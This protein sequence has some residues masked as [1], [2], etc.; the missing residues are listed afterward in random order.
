MTYFW[1]G[2]CRSSCSCTTIQLFPRTKG[3]DWRTVDRA[4]A[5]HTSELRWSRVW[6]SMSLNPVGVIFLS[7]MWTGCMRCV[8]TPG[9]LLLEYDHVVSQTISRGPK[10]SRLRLQLAHSLLQMRWSDENLTFYFW[11]IVSALHCAYELYLFLQRQYPPSMWQ[12]D[13]D[14]CMMPKP[15]TWKILLHKYLLWWLLLKYNMYR[16]Q[17]EGTL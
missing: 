17:S 15:P 2:I 16:H 10:H 1:L 4:W 13:L 5:L 8:F 12:W 6:V 7:Q 3:H 11:N 9:W 14:F